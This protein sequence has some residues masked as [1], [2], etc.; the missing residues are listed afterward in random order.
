MGSPY[1][2]C[3]IELVGTDK[4][5]LPQAF[6][7]DKFAWTDDSKKLVLV[8]WHSTGEHPVFK[9]FII[10]IETGVT[11]E[12]IRMI[13]AINNLKVKGDTISYTKFY[14]KEIMSKDTLCCTVQEDYVLKNNKY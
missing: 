9:L 12:G 13:G 5:Q 2:T 11:Q 6:W 14:Y 3:K 7:Q 10:D 1:N 4:I 8:K